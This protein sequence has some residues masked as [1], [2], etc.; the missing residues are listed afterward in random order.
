MSTV[1]ITGA[2]S[3]LGRALAHQY[4]AAGYRVIVTGRTEKKLLVVQSEI[5]EKEDRQKLL[6]VM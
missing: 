1:F 4:G 6:S 5:E 3:G 2:G